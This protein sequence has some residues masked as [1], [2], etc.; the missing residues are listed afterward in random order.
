MGSSPPELMALLALG[1]A[2]ADNDLRATLSPHLESWRRNPRLA[3]V[4]LNGLA[5]KRQPSMAAKVLDFMVESKVEVNA[6]HYNSAISACG[7]GG[8]WPLALSLFSSMPGSRVAPDAISFNAAISACEKGGQWQLA[9]SLLNSMPEMRP[10]PDEISHN[11]AIS[12]C[13]KGNQ[14]Q[15]ALAILSMMP[16]ARLTPTIVSYNA[17]VSACEKGGQWPL[18]LSLLSSM[19]GM[20]CIPDAISFSAAIS[21]C[22]KG[23]QWQIALRILSDMP[24]RRAT[25]NEFSYSATIS[26]CAK[27]GQWQHAI[28]LLCGMPDMKAKPNQISFNSAISAC[29]KAGQ[30]QHALS[31][32]IQMT[33]L[34]AHPDHISFNAAISACSKGGQWKL[35]LSL[36]SSMPE[37]AAR[38]DEISY[39]AAIT[40]CERGGQWQLALNLLSTMPQMRALPNEISYTA[41]ISACSKGGQWVEALRLLSIMPTMS[42][43]PNA[44]SFTAAISACERASQ[45]QFAL[46]LLSTMAEMRV[47][48]DEFSCSASISACAKGGQWQKAMH[49]LSTMPQMKV[50]PNE[51][52][53][54]AAMEALESGSQW[55]AALT[56]LEDMRAVGV[57]SILARSAAIATC[58]KASCWHEALQLGL[59]MRVTSEV[60]LGGSFGVLLM[61]CEQRSL[62]SLELSTSRRL[63]DAAR[64]GGLLLGLAAVFDF[65]AELRRGGGSSRNAIPRSL[66]E[67]L[68]VGVACSHV[69]TRSLPYHREL[70]LLRHVLENAQTGN[71]AAVAEA[72][73]AFGRDLGS[74][75]SWAKFAGG[76]KAEALLAAMRGGTPACH[77]NNNHNSAT[78]GVLEI[79]TYCGNSALRLAASLPGVRVTTLELDPVL[80]AIARTLIA[81]AGLASSVDVWTG[82][83]T[84]LIPRLANW[85]A[86]HH[87]SYFSAIFMDRW[88][89]YYDEDLALLQEHKL[90]QETGGVLVADNVLTT[91]AASFLWNVARPSATFVS[92][93]VAVSEVADSSQE[94]WVSVSVSISPT[95]GLQSCADL[96]LELAQLQAESEQL[97]QRIIVAG[98]FGAEVAKWEK[99]AFAQRA[100]T[101]LA[102]AGIAP[103]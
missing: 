86:Q 80:V 60:D 26:A 39:S 16:H 47:L 8:Q 36:L 101:V 7:K 70:A 3:T 54:C 65:S 20:S 23:G 17:A 59:E 88:G 50:L 9:L 87:S 63:S 14:W 79:G 6:F 38:P 18:A 46:R 31:L 66:L 15:H 49:L 40:A 56:L 84:R 41:A 58:S 45:W 57:D 75:G 83:S 11:A 97:R 94:D 67:P 35:A 64:Q 5:K 92:Q 100:K 55:L 62:L 81:F 4:V 98:G 30:W 61:E 102:R 103:I 28:S 21:A 34:H 51:I 33:A 19:P 78:A 53:F 69:S 96:P 13:E 77:N 76:S 1:P 91:A 72:L 32:L 12:A 48:Y 85:L 99:P 22:E 90:L 68:L 71:P 37:M 74:S 82:H 52:T 10:M 95:S 42:A 2:F 93:V 29:E 25:P 73:D 89:T 44:I 43:T 24:E 27:G